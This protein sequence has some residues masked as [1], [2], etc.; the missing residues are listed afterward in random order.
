M[1]QL[2]VAVVGAG[3]IAQQHLKVLTSHPECRV[4][5]LCDLDPISRTETAKR[6]GIPEHFD[7]T[8]AVVRRDDIDAVFVLVS[9][10]AVAAVATEFLMAG[11]PTFLEKPPGLYS[12]DTERLAEIAHRQGSIAMVG[13]NRRFYASHLALE[14]RLRA[15]SPLA[16]ITVEAHEDLVPLAARWR[17]TRGSEVPEAVFRRWA[18]ANG[19]H[20]LDLLRFF[21]GEV[22][23]IHSHVHARF[24]Q[25][26]PDAHTAVLRFANG[27]HGRALIDWMAPGEHRFDLRGVGVRATSQPGFGVT[28]LAQRGE[29]ESSLEPDV[30]DLRFKPGFWKQDS[31]FLNTVR[32]GRGPQFP[33]ASLADAHRTM[34]LIEQICHLPDRGC[35]V[36]PSV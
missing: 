18:I 23:E 4:V 8:K 13:L 31:A 14:Q 7:G 32:E 5:L 28:T 12:T 3:N 1:S 30:D 26:F 25:D 10:T 35:D 22:T 29:E 27:A 9:V 2:R 6:F 19:I 11:M 17:A 36:V 24:E 15:Q 34:V 33:A 21:G 16:T 20:A